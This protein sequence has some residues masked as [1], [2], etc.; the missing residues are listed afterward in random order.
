MHAARALVPSRVLFALVLR[1]SFAASCAA[2]VGAVAFAPSTAAATP[3]PGS[4]ANACGCYRDDSGVCFCEKKSKCGCEGE[5]EP[6]GCD[7]KRAKE[8]A[9]ELENEVKLAKQRGGS[10]HDDKTDDSGHGK[11][12]GAEG[13]SHEEHSSHAGQEPKSSRATKS[14]VANDDNDGATCP[15]CPCMEAQKNKKKDKGG[16][17]KGAE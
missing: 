17:A 3:P 5:C 12:H 14:D 11:S 2:S 10:S 15:P 1:F 4:T 7:D 13:S 16:K 9:K 6:K 8:R